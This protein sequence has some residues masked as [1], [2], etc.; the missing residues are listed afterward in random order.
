[1]FNPETAIG[2]NPTAVNTEN[3]PPTSSGIINVS[4]PSLSASVLSAPLAL[5]VVAN[6]L[7]LAPSLPYL[8]SNILLNVLNAIAVSVVVPD[9]EITFT[10]KSLSFINSVKC[11]KYLP[12][13][14]LPAKYILGV[15]LTLSSKSL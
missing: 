12:E 5:S 10:L 9:F 2:N 8:S 7:S 13:I 1:M 6:I 3:L 14:L 15:F 4:Y 11:F